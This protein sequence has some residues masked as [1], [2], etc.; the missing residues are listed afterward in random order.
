MGTRRGIYRILAGKSDGRR[1]LGKPRR[2]WENN[3]KM[4]LR[5]IGWGTWTGSIW[6]R[7]GTGG[8]LL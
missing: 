3:I 8:G 1:P 2:R 7:V 4:D 6:L 5:E